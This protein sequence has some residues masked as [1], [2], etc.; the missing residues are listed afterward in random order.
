MQAGVHQDIPAS[1]Q[2]MELW[3]R[4]DGLGLPLE[5]GTGGLTKYNRQ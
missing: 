1:P 2:R 3:Q 5:T 4:L